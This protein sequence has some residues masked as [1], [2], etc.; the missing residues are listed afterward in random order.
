ML[1][2]WFRKAKVVA[3]ALAASVL[4]GSP[5]DASAQ[6]PIRIGVLNGASGI[7]SSIGGQG[8][9][10]AARLAAADV[11]GKVLNRPIEIVSANHQ[12]NADVARSIALSWFDQD[13]VV[14]IADLNLTA[15]AL[16]VVDAGRIKHRTTL[17]SGA[18][19]ADFTGKWCSPYS[20]MW[21]DDTWTLTHG[22]AQAL[23]SQGL[24]TWY[25]VVA[26]I[27][28]GNALV[29]D[30]SE[31]VNADGGHVLGTV[32]HPL[33][34]SDF[35]SYLLTAQSSGAKVV[36]LGSAGAD[37]VN[38]LKQAAEF[39]LIPAQRMTAFL[40]FI[41][42]I[43]AV[44]AQ[45]AQGT[46][47]LSGFYWNQSDPARDFAR[48]FEQEMGRVP[49]KEQA[50]VYASVRH[51]L[52]AVEAAGTTDAAAVGVEMRKLPVDFLGRPGRIRRDGRVL[53]DVS[54]YRVKA[55]GA[56]SGPWDL[57]EEVKRLPMATAY[58]PEDPAPCKG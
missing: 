41:T 1:S 23:L 4:A 39:G 57:Y 10:V 19:N 25:F 48:R 44:G 58:H 54:L 32:R 52:R 55:P 8:S 13:D 17:I 27:A 3:L 45:Q 21:S 9:V 18:A 28:F 50:A 2:K 30:A 34:T 35:S 37:T 11:G 29:T 12:D 31:V 20:T 15:P 22:L 46:L 51:F 7:A 16:A 38:A 6:A 42:D 5:H 24:D 49:T 14:A 47:L 43:K 53:Y 40:P 26:D 36:A 33:G 56:S